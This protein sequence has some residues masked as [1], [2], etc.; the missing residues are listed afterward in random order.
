ME[1]EKKKQFSDNKK[2]G[3]FL[4][5]QSSFFYIYFFKKEKFY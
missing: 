1:V 2:K 5:E 4:G 3:K